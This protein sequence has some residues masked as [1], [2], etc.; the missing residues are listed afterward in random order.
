MSSNKVLR[1]KYVS[2]KNDEYWE[3]TFEHT[4]VAHGY[5]YDLGNKIAENYR[6][7]YKPGK[8]LVGDQKLTQHVSVLHKLMGKDTPTKL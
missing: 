2:N 6:K 8:F 5:G 7:K 1:L 3:I 4:V